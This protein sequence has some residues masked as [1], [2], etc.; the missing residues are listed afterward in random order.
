MEYRNVL[1]VVNELF[2]SGPEYHQSP[3]II[4]GVSQVPSMLLNLLKRR[5]LLFDQVSQ[6][7]VGFVAQVVEDDF[8]SG[9]GLVVPERLQADELVEIRER[10]PYIALGDSGSAGSSRKFKNRSPRA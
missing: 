2:D 10:H 8:V 1:S 3:G 7:T 6:L 4:Y 9:L 5:Q